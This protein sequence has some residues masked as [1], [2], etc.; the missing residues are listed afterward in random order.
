MNWAAV[1][2]SPP[3]AEFDVRVAE[4]ASD[5]ARV[6]LGDR[7]VSFDHLIFEARAEA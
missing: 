7:R 6:E 5:S 1:R 4:A 3:C 2:H